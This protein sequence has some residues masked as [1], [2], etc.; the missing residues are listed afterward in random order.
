MFISGHSNIGGGEG[1]PAFFFFFCKA[2]LS[3]DT[4]SENKFLIELAILYCRNL[5]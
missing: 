4:I 2:I 3:N 5:G 1:A